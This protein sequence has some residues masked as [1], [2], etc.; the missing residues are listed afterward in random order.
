M[1]R[2]PKVLAGGVAAVVLT[3]AI[4]GAAAFAQSTP[5]ANPTAAAQ[6]R[7]QEAQAFLSDFAS[8]LGKSPTDVLAAFKQ[9]EKDQ[10]ASAVQAGRLTQQQADQVNQRIDQQQGIPFGGPG[11]GERGHGPG[12]P[13]F[14]PG[15][16]QA[17]ATWLGVQPADL[18]TALRSNQSLAQIAQAHG[19]SRDDLK[20]FLVQQ[21]K[22]RLD[23]AVQAGK[24]TQDQENQRLSDLSSRL[25]QMIDRTGPPP[26]GPRGPRGRGGPG[27]QA[28]GAQP[29]STPTR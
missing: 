4:G 26:G 6:Q 1:P 15:G 14:G 24:L 3:A 18:M 22:A 2:I 10:V 28:S 29:T 21:E 25:D 7:A 11:F 16:D 23:Q 20:Q 19:K 8:K 9:A 13:G 27:A 17:L 12:G 5:T